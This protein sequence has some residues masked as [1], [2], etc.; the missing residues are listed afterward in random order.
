MSDLIALLDATLRLISNSGPDKKKLSKL[1]VTGV[2]PG[3][4]PVDMF[5]DGLSDNERENYQCG[6]W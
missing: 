6:I 1:P 2:K 5:L 3:G 4:Y